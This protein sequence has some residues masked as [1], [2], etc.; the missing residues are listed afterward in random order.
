MALTIK[1][2]HKHISSEWFNFLTIKTKI[3]NHED[4]F[5]CN[6]TPNGPFGEGITMDTTTPPVLKGAS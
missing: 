3:P 6:Y 4:Q 1:R 2:L 5:L